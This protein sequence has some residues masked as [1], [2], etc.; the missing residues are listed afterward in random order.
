MRLGVVIGDMRVWQQNK[1]IWDGTR[2][3]VGGIG[4]QKEAGW[5]GDTEGAVRKGPSQ[6]YNNAST[7]SHDLLWQ[8]GE[9][10]VC[11]ILHD[12]IRLEP[13]WHANMKILTE[14]FLKTRDMQYAVERACALPMSSEY[15]RWM[16]KVLS[17]HRN[18]GDRVQCWICGA[19]ATR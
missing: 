3:L 19:L 18:S 17:K 8:S 9:V 10:I 12:I 1:T 6:H 13:S 7:G 11:T 4:R 15:T 2:F 5:V 14:V 16:T